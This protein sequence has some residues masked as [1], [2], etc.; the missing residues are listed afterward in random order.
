MAWND[1]NVHRKAHSPRSVQ[2]PPSAFP[3][4]NSGECTKESQ[5]DISDT[6]LANCRPLNL[7]TFSEVLADLKSLTRGCTPPPATILFWFSMFSVVK[8]IMAMPAIN[9]R[10]SDLS[11]NMSTRMLMP[12]MLAMRCCWCGVT[13]ASA[14][15]ALAP[16]TPKN[17]A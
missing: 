17:T 4:R 16:E 7:Q 15:R 8:A 9:C 2:Q 3:I 6:F 5:Q 14:H 12:I 11:I 10:V 13:P 1:L